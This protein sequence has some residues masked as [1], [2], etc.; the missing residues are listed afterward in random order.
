MKIFHEE[1]GRN[2]VYVQV[3]D[4]LFIVK[5]LG[6][7]LIPASICCKIFCNDGATITCSNQY[8]FIKFNSDLEISFFKKLDFVIDYDDYKDLSD[9]QLKNHYNNV[10][11]DYISSI[12]RWTRMSNEDQKKNTELKIC[13]KKQRHM[14]KYIEEIYNLKHHPRDWYFPFVE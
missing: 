13:I 12:K 14:M 10:F 4:I 5:N 7:M 2:V 9:E 11:L 1:D 6:D 3:D 8:D